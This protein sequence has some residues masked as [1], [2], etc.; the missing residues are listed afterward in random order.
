MKPVI[1]VLIL[2]ISNQC[3]AESIFGIEIGAPFSVQKCGKDADK[4]LVCYDDFL[5]KPVDH[6][7][8]ARSY[9][10]N[11]QPGSVEWGIQQYGFRVV[12]FNEEVVGVTITTYGYQWQDEIFADLRKKFGKPSSQSTSRLQNSFG[13]KINGIKAKWDKQSLKVEFD[14]VWG[15]IGD[16]FILIEAKTQSA[17]DEKRA[18]SEWRKANKPT[19][20]F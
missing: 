15:K 17:L 11:V 13:A 1:A 3:A 16:G 12:T 2:A 5:S 10:I 4:S 8:G 19:A 18:E 6:P 20:K 14:G 9:G 7:W